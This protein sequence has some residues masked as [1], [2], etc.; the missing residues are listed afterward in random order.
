[1]FSVTKGRNKKVII[2]S[3]VYGQFVPKFFAVWQTRFE[4]C[5][6]TEIFFPEGYDVVLSIV[7]NFLFNQMSCEIL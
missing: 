6:N 5:R 3:N 1:M 2:I 4:V 7:L